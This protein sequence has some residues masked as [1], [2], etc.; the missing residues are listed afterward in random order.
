MLYDWNFRNKQKAIKKKESHM[1]EETKTRIELEPKQVGGITLEKV[2]SSPPQISTTV[3]PSRQMEIKGVKL[4]MNSNVSI[5]F[6]FVGSG[7][8]G[9][10]IA[11]AFGALGYPACAINTAQ[12]DLQYIK[13]PEDRKLVM[14]YGLGG[15][16]R[17]VGI[18][19]EAFN[20][21]EEQVKDLLDRTFNGDVDYFVACV[22]G[23][24]GTGSGSAEG[25][26]KL[27]SAYQ[28]PVG[29]IYTLPSS[30]EDPATKANAVKILD[31]LSKLSKDGILTT[32]IIVDN[33]KIEQIYPGLSAA[34]FWSRAN[35]DI[36][37]ILHQFNRLSSQ[38]SRFVSL[39]PTDLA[40]VL[41]D[42]GYTIYGSARVA[43]YNGTDGLVNAVVNSVKNG[44][45]ASEF[46]ISETTTAGVIFAGS[47]EVL[48]NIPNEDIDYALFELSNLTGHAATFKGIYDLDT[49]DVG[50]GLLVLTML[51]GLGSPHKR[52]QSLASESEIGSDAIAAKKSNKDK[53]T[54][55]DNDSAS[56][57]L[58]RFK[59]MR[60]KHSPLGRMLDNRN[61][62][63]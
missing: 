24:G 26:V 49:Q 1:P 30:N 13:L 20:N 33:S 39:D 53:M 2:E 21:Y 47:Y 23:G 18:G 28:L 17:D 8:G 14:S 15:A 56:D 12:V 54:I 44:L 27:L 55:T 19:S 6:G 52:I 37:N 7:Q 40:R 29:V 5:R 57:D 51:S 10:R 63:K 62:T 34:N 50:R 60:T 46:N 58:D 4:A 43:E 3:S 31:K 48:S 59:S 35:V 38:P 61:K 42:G 36:A 32:L 9:S 16:G 45:L 25:L 11:E 22:G 41:T